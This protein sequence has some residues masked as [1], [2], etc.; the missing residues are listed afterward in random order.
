MKTAK[1]WGFPLWMAVSEMPKSAVFSGSVW[2]C[3][4]NPLWKT[5]FGLMWVRPNKE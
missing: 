4:G 3:K 2:N 1:N 5:S